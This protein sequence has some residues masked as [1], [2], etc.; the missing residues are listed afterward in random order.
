MML[1]TRAVALII[2]SC[3]ITLI[4]CQPR[5]LGR[6][7]LS[8]FTSCRATQKDAIEKAFRDAIDFCKVASDRLTRLE[9]DELDSDAGILEYLGPALQNRNFRQTAIG[10]LFFP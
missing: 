1:E 8:G 5:T 2:F 3:I 9:E 4:D 7:R 10:E 6:L